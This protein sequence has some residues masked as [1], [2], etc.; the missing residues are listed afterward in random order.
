MSD[1]VCTD[2]PDCKPSLC[3]VHRFLGPLRDAVERLPGVTALNLNDGCSRIVY[4]SKSGRFVYKVPRSKR[5]LEDNDFEAQAWKHR[6]EAK[7]KCGNLVGDF[8]ARCRMAPSGV[9]VMEYL[10]EDFAKMPKRGSPERPWFLNS[11]DDDQ[12]GMS[13]D[14]RYLLFDYALCVDVGNRL[15]S[16]WF[17]TEKEI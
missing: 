8:L 1:C 16:Y 7:T 6:D 14:G 15:R 17:G 3:D 12:G 2:Y 9:L 10:D 11:I 4:L 13:R 5:G